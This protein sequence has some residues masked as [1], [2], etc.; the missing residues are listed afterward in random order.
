MR[1]QH[2]AVLAALFATPACGTFVAPVV[3]PQGLFFSA[4]S[5]PIDTNA[6]KTPVC[7]KMGEASSSAFFFNFFA[8]GDCS[9]D[10]AARN[11]G[12]QTIEHIDYSAFN[13]MFF[14]QRFTVRA[15]G[16]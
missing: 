9:L 10:T 15:W 1:L 2:L 14:Y 6:A 4:T 8:M 7:S 16:N 11:G 3:P 12:L 5:A 13:V